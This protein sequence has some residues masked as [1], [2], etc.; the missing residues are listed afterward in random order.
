[1]KAWLIGVAL[2]LVACSPRYRVVQE[3]M[4]GSRPFSWYESCSYSCGS[5]V[6]L[7]FEGRPV[8]TPCTAHG[9]RLVT[10]VQE[11]WMQELED[12]K[13]KEPEAPHVWNRVFINVPKTRDA[14]Q[15]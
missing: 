6:S 15:P 7:D 10:G 11:T 13:A 2:L 8:I 12:L 4:E 1:M 5:N 9:T 3:H 14:C